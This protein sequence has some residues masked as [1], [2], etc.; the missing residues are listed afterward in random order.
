[1]PRRRR[2]YDKHRLEGE[3]TY[4]NL[5]GRSGVASYAVGPE[6]IRVRFTS[7]ATYRYTDDTSGPRSVEHMKNLANGGEFL[8]RYLNSFKPGYSSRR[9]RRRR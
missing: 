5:S 1:M 8:N 2:P 9:R 4:A 6:I 3:Q 7:G